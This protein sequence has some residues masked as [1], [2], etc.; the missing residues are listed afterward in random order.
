MIF[1]LAFFALWLLGLR[2]ATRHAFPDPIFHSEPGEELGPVYFPSLFFHCSLVLALLGVLA[3]VLLQDLRAIWL[4]VPGSAMPIFIG[5]YIE[6]TFIVE[7]KDNPLHLS[8]YWL[9]R[10]WP[11]LLLSVALAGLG[12]GWS[13]R[14]ESFFPLLFV[15]YSAFFLFQFW[16]FYSHCNGVTISHLTF[17]TTANFPRMHEVA[18]RTVR[19]KSLSMTI[20]ETRRWHSARL[21]QVTI[22]RDNEDPIEMISRITPTQLIRIDAEFGDSSEG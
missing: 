13:I 8:P 19:P 5:C 12:V 2:L 9:D 16:F 20:E 3:C 17:E 22:T 6:Y 7:R 14:S 21:W 10:Q 4:A 18:T 11:F 15:F 1:W